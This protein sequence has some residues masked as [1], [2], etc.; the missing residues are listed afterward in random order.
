MAVPVEK[1]QIAKDVENL[2]IVRDL[3][4]KAVDEELVEKLLKT[5]IEVRYDERYIKE[6]IKT[7][8]I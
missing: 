1:L 2:N 6:L 3:Q 7:F 8:Q 4:S 5:N